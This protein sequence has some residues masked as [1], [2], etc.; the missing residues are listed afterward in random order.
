MIGK[1]RP[2]IFLSIV[3]LGIL[4]ICG[5]QSGYN[6]IASGCVG[7]IIALGMK[8]LEGSGPE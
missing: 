8:V 1:V 4:A 5:V 7:G 3:V 6:E 2:Q